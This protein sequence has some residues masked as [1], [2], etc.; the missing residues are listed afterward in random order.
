MRTASL[1]ATLLAA[2]AASAV[3]YSSR[4]PKNT[5]KRAASLFDGTTVSTFWGQSTENLSDVCDNGNFNVVIMSFITSLN[6]PKLNLGKDT[7]S[8]STAQAAQPDWELFDGTV[9][10]DNSSLAD[11][12][13]ACQKKG[14]KVMIAFGGDSRYSN[15]TFGSSDEARQAADYLWYAPMFPKLNLTNDR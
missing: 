13:T 9:E 4:F 14:I 6:P 10:T 8:P 5:V 11:Q 15:S 3:P 2:S 12:I 1:A 7:G